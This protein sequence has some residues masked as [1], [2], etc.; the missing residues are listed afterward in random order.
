M[1][2]PLKESDQTTVKPGIVS[3]SEA[4]ANGRRRRIIVVKLMSE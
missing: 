1:E 2:D 4:L 3:G